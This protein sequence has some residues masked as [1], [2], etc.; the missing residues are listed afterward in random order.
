L[1]FDEE[2]G[3]VFDGGVCV[4]VIEY[5]DGVELSAV[6]RPQPVQTASV[7]ESEL[8]R[9]ER[10]LHEHGA[11]EANAR[12]VERRRCRQQRSAEESVRRARTRV[13]RIVRAY[14]LR[15]MVTLTFPGD[16]VHDYDRALRLIQ[17]FVHDHGTTVHHGDHYV[18]VPELHPAGHGW[19]WHV[20]V[21][22]RFTK[23][24]LKALWCGWTAFLGR[25]EM[26]PS[27]G[28]HY[29]RIDIKA[30]TSP[31]A[32]S[33][34]AAKYVGKSFGDS[35]HGKHRRRFLASRGA[36]VDAQKASADSLS[37][38]LRVIESVPGA[39]VRRIEADQGR[40]ALVWAAW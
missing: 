15:Y 28:A 31:S 3:E 27:G 40:P 18:A 36:V 38:V 13:R 22:R 30:W 6:P 29:V 32:A 39:V 23:S 16:G 7:K 25:R 14:G 21:S 1:R 37:E 10:E 26:H 12:A 2:T 35:G 33:S 9:Y 8:Q 24:E 17:D 5:P 19:H 20:L 34:Y 4:S 11:A